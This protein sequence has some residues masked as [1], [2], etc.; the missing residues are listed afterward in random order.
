MYVAPAITETDMPRN[1]DLTALRSF[2]TV[3]DS[4]GVTRAAL[5]LNL[6]QSAVS[7][8]LKRLEDSVGQ[9]LL[10]RS[11]RGVA[12]T[13]QGEQLAGF[14]RRMLALNDEAWGHLTNQAYEGEIAL[15]VPHDI[16]YPHIP[17]ALHRFACEFPR[18]QVKLHSSF[19]AELKLQMT[20]G[21]MDVILTTE[22]GVDTGGMVLDR[23]PLTWIG[24]QGGV[25]W[26]TRPV[27]FASVSRCIFKRP[28]IDALERAGL[29]WALTVDAQSFS[30]VDASVSADLAVCVQLE[31]AVPRLCEVIR[32]NGALPALPDYLVNMYVTDG[33][34]AA[35]A[36]RLAEMIRESYGRGEQK[37]A[38][39]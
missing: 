15:G 5:Q 9:P 35:L 29:P 26:R 13:P 4:G 30:A 14:A 3:A 38:A 37:I 34:R 39:E 33:P 23:Q 36:E 20:R 1:L 8:Q 22:A 32:H 10:D 12:L 11:G 31:S 16:I 19:T 24:A 6:T 2:V 7:M 27:R 25:V 18:V 28:A 17:K 21:E